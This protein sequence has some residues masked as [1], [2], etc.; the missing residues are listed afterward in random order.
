MAGLG[1]QVEYFIR[2]PKKYQGHLRRLSW[3]KKPPNVGAGFQTAGGLV[4]GEELMT[5]VPACGAS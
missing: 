5:G 3:V 1:I 4:M 2:I